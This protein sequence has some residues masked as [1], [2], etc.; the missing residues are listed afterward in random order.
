MESFQGRDRKSQGRDRIWLV[1]RFLA[2]PGT[3]VTGV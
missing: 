2:Y 3:Y 1:Q